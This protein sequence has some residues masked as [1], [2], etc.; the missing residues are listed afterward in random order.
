MSWAAGNFPLQGMGQFMFPKAPPT[1]RMDLY[2]FQTWNR[3]EMC[4]D[5]VVYWS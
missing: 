4:G 3:E 5:L 1:L 2:W